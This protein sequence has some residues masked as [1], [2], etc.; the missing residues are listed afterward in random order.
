MR[1]R[2][3]TVEQGPAVLDY[4]ELY[5]T[6]EIIENIFTEINRYA[7]RFLTNAKEKRNTLFLGRGEPLTTNER[8]TFLGVS[9]LMGT[10]YKPKM[11]IHWSKDSLYS[12]PIFS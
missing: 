10:I 1:I 2:T 8:K 11:R 9:L 12:T 4:V 3:Q 5:L 6:D 7:E